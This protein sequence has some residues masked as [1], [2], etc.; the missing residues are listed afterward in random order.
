MCYILIMNPFTTGHRALENKEITQG[1]N[2]K[3]QKQADQEQSMQK[4]ENS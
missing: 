3:V 4:E 1:Y 2:Q